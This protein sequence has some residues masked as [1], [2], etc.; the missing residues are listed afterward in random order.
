MERSNFFKCPYLRVNMTFESKRGHIVLLRVWTSAL[1]RG[2]YFWCSETRTR[3]CVRV[4]VHECRHINQ[5][6][7]T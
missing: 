2:D 1:E 7:G 3:E 6:H 5:L 4:Y